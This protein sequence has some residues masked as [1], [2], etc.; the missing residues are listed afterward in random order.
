MRPNWKAQKRFTKDFLARHKILRRNTQNFTEVEPALA[1]LREKGAPIVIKAD[2]LA[3][4]KG[5]IVAMTL[6]EAEAAVHDMLAGQT[7]LATRVIASLSKSS[8]MAKK[9]A[10]S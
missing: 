9:R 6:E 1:Y 7:L 5:V 8:S 10:L 2:G 4:G 3:A